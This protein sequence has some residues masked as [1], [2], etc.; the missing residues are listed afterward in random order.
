MAVSE[1]KKI[2]LL[3]GESV[4]DAIGDLV[5]LQ[6]GEVLTDDWP[7]S[8]RHSR[9]SM[10]RTTWELRFHVIAI[11]RNRCGVTLEIEEAD[12]TWDDEAAE[13]Q[14][15]YL[16]DMIRRQF[17]L[18]D[19]LLLME[20]I[21]N[22]ACEDAADGRDN[23]RIGQK[24]YLH[25]YDLLL[26]A[27]HDMAYLQKG[28]ILASDSGRGFVRILVEV[29]GTEREYRFTVD[30][31]GCSE[32]SVSIAL[33]GDGEET[34]RLIDHEFALLE[35][36]LVDR[37][38]FE[39]A[40]IEAFERQ[41]SE[42]RRLAQEALQ[43][44]P[45]AAAEAK[46]E[47]AAEAEAIFAEG[48]T[49]G[50]AETGATTSTAATA[51]DMQG[52]LAEVESADMQ[53]EQ[54]AQPVAVSADGAAKPASPGKRNKILGYAVT[55]A[56]AA[57]VVLCLFM[58]GSRKAPVTLP[59]APT[60]LSAYPASVQADGAGGCTCPCETENEQGCDLC[61]SCANR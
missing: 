17:A 26:S 42:E 57:V 49:V 55:G 51:A 14:R 16:E 20:P 31:I 33:A 6:K 43:E 45:G 35:Y 8:K 4:Y 28:K 2:Y 7:G 56:I 38:K 21:Q 1:G 22:I 3:S 44:A 27:I 19:S 59:E 53:V 13:D 25:P 52:S 37:T 9:I 11:D 36:V 32:C 24:R 40:D 29:Y 46:A 60:P 54:Q 18:L 12:W 47:A 41:L 48:Q 30:G 39:L 23:D 50:T 61:A 34:R 15:V 10:Y 5:E 58:A